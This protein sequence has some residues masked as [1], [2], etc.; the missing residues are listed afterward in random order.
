MKKILLLFVLMTSLVFTSEAQ[1]LKQKKV[2]LELLKAFRDQYPAAADVEWRKS[3]VGF[4]IKYEFLGKKQESLY[5]KEFLWV[6][7]IAEMSAAE[8]SYATTSFLK[9]RFPDCSLADI[10]LYDTPL[11]KEHRLQILCNK[12]YS[13]LVF[14]ERG[15]LLR[16]E[17][18]NNTSK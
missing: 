7:T 12:L 17:I 10:T 6:N 2:P 5:T 4:V 1:R 18:Q 13:N 8:L 11:T 14:D 9:Q 3:R 15:N 16:E